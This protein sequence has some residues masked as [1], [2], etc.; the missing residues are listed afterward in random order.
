MKFFSTYMRQYQFIDLVVTMTVHTR[1]P[2]QISQGDIHIHIY[3][4]AE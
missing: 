2:R 3:N 4:T 1:E